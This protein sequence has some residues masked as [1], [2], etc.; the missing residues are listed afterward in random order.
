MRQP[1]LA[2]KH[3]ERKL[4][5]LRSMELAPPTRGWLRALREALGMTSAQL[6]AR[7]RVVP[8]RVSA[9]EKAEATG[10][11]TIKSMR[12]AAEA[13]GCTFVYAIVPTRPLDELMQTRA[14]ALADAELA[15][16]HHTMRLEDQALDA[17][18]LADARERLIATYLEGN[19]RRLWDAP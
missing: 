12:E 8:S 5:P 16:V 14:A 19:P 4:S 1:E 18:D 10:G 11:T 2:R 3:L 13:M 17:R 6:A 7:L 9:L 15:R